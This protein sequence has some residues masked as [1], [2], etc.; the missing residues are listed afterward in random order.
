MK[1]SE[2]LEAFKDRLCSTNRVWV[3]YSGGLDSSLLLHASVQLLGA[4]RV[5]ALHLNHQLDENSNHW[6]RHCAS[7]AEKLGI[8]FRSSALDV[9]NRGG[10]I[11]NEARELRYEF[12]EANLSDNE[13]LLL[14]HHADDQAET[15]LYRLVRGT[16]ARGLVGIPEYRDLGAGGVLRP[17]LSFTRNQLRE[18]AEAESICWIDDPSNSDTR[19]DRNYIRSRLKPN[20]ED[21]WPSAVKTLNQVA[22]NMRASVQLQEEYGALLLESCKWQPEAAGYSFDIDSYAALSLPAQNLVLET[23]LRIQGLAG[24][25]SKLQ[26][27]VREVIQSGEDR[28]PLIAFAGAEI[29][30]YAKRVY[31]MPALITEPESNY[32]CE[33]DGLGS[34]TL[35]NCGQVSL[36]GNYSGP[37]LRLTFRQGGETCRPLGRDQSQSLKKLMQEYELEPWLR[38]RIPLVWVGEEL[39]GVAGLFSCSKDLPPV[40]LDWQLSEEDASK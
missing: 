25:D 36:A 24:F 6:Q 9:K 1:S 26:Q 10:G 38:T 35:P 39:L 12:F 3:G 30:R 34:K 2:L 33:W 14:A 4:Q 7:T 18:I 27:K 29:R 13:L 28:S 19:Y 22:S 8:E 37:A 15:V 23:G 16:G 11:E 5:G 20:I 21:R 32:V 31:L 40:E 17:F